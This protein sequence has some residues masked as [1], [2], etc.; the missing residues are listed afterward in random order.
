MDISSA[1]TDV[2]VAV[3]DTLYVCRPFDSS[4]LGA[5]VGTFG[6]LTS[7][8][9][10]RLKPQTPKIHGYVAVNARNV[11]AGAKAQMAF[12]NN[13]TA[14]LLSEGGQQYA[15]EV[16]SQ[17]YYPR[18]TGM[19]PKAEAPA[20]PTVIPP[21]NNSD[22]I[23]PKKT[24]PES[25]RPTILHK[26]SQEQDVDQL[27]R[28]SQLEATIE[29][30]QTRIKEQQDQ[31]RRLELARTETTPPAA[32]Y[33][34]TGSGHWIGMVSSNGRFVTLEDR[35]LW[36]INSIDQIDTALWLPTTDIIVRAASSP[37]GDFKYLLI[38]TEDG[39]QALAKYVGS[40]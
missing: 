8:G 12:F 6:A 19:E 36:D 34:A 17:R 24:K 33:R 16:V 9:W 28:V 27:T 38:N 21:G 13:G 3:S 5:V 10:D 7:G 32:A 2:S 25:E 4:V 30:L 14:R 23:G 1:Y 26:G 29:N 31:I 22:S 39:E 20:A 15:C 35:S 11:R 18:E 37:V 40:N